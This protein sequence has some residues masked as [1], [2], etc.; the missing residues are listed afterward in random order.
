M[1]LAG[2][3]TAVSSP[4]HLGHAACGSHPVPLLPRAEPGGRL[5]YPATPPVQGASAPTLACLAAGG[6]R[7]RVEQD[8]VQAQLQRISRQ[9][10]ACH[11]ARQRKL[12]PRI[13]PAMQPLRQRTLHLRSING[14][15][16]GV[17]WRSGSRRE[18]RA[19]AGSQFAP[20]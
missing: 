19:V 12:G 17:S 3:R 10:A 5:R 6:R 13:G 15:V 1:F 14:W 11:G 18:R 8:G 20:S 4:P 7:A 16:G 2:V 9:D